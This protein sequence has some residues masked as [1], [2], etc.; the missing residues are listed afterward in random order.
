MFITWLEPRSW[1]INV[2]SKR[3]WGRNVWSKTTSRKTAN[4][5]SEPPWERLFL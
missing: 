3:T 1:G 2:W 5:C 4:N